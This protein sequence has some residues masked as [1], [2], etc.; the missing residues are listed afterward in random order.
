MRR[1][2]RGPN[3]ACRWSRR[4]QSR[5]YAEW[6]TDASRHRLE[7]GRCCPRGFNITPGG[8]IQAFFSLGM[9]TGCMQRTSGGFAQHV[10]I[11]PKA[12]LEPVG[13]WTG[14][15]CWRLASERVWWG[16]GDPLRRCLSK[17]DQLAGKHGHGGRCHSRRR[18]NGNF[19]ARRGC[20]Y[21]RAWRT[22]GAFSDPGTGAHGNGDNILCAA[23]PGRSPRWRA[24]GVG[25]ASL[26]LPG[27]YGALRAAGL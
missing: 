25:P 26:G 9:V 27:G 16:R 19:I 12:V 15:R 20:P 5:V 2:E 4:T 14:C 1:R 17:P 8:G 13:R 7:L 21:G 18:A 11:D 24:R 10:S 22:R 6:L 3:S 23:R